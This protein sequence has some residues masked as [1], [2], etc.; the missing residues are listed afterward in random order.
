[1]HTVESW[2]KAYL[3][4]IAVPAEAAKTGCA[5]CIRHDPPIGSLQGFCMKG[6]ALNRTRP[7]I[8]SIEMKVRF[9]RSSE[10][11]GAKVYLTHHDTIGTMP[12]RVH[13]T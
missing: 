11:A 8:D 4:V 7:S 1:M 6:L 13:G 5:S 10:F 2:S 9:S 12:M 3:A